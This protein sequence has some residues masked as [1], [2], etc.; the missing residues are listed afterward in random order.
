M[1]AVK[2]K[3]DW[4]TSFQQR[5]LARIKKHNYVFQRFPRNILLQ[6]PQG[7]SE[8]WEALAFAQYSDGVE[9]QTQ[10]LMLAQLLR[11][12][13]ALYRTVFLRCI[14]AIDAAIYHDDGLDG[15]EGQVVL[16]DIVDAQATL[17]EEEP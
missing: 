2:E 14:R 16:K 6:P 15:A 11:V 1:S 5:Q 17:E 9:L 10:A 12:E 13:R 8:R 4:I 7:E 3:L